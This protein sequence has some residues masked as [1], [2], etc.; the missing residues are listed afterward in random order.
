MQTGQVSI[1]LPDGTLIEP[2]TKKK[3]LGMGWYGLER[4]AMDWYGFEWVGIGW[5]VLVWVGMSWYGL[6]RVG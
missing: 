3:N 5:K 1:T 6:V 2:V 4:V